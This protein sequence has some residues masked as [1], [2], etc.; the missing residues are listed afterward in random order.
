LKD[1]HLFFIGFFICCD[2]KNQS[3]HPTFS[4]ANRTFFGLPP[5]THQPKN[6]IYKFKVGVHK[7]RPIKLKQTLHLAP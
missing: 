4:M 5:K 7:I 6:G 2:A 3:D 1:D